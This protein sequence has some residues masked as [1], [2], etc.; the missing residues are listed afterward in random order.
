MYEWACPEDG[1]ALTD[2]VAPPLQ[3]LLQFTRTVPGFDLLDF[4]DQCSLLSMSSLDVMFL[5]S[6]QQFSQNPTSSSP[7]LQFFTVSTHT[8]LRNLESRP[9]H[10]G[11]TWAGPGPGCTK[12]LLGGA[13]LLGAV[14]CF[15]HSM[16]ALRATEAEYALLTATALLCSDRASQQVAGCVDKMQELIL[17]LLSRVCG[18]EGGGGGGAR[19]AEGGGGG[20]RGGAQRFGR[21][22]GRLT[23]L[24]SLR[25]NYLHLRR[26]QEEL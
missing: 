13:D 10:Q 19:G 17:D 20:A 11:Q 8:R 4:T 5:L 26:Q 6:A 18:P 1:V 24:R 15:F 25:H 21:L 7:A 22:L 23:E 9:D 14:L 2:V 12:D 3:R 16:A